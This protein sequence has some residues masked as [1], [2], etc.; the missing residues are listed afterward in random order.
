MKEDNVE[1]I[2]V[3]L[4]G[5]KIKLEIDLSNCVSCLKYR[6]FETTKIHP[7][8]QTLKYGEKVLSNDAEAITF[9]G[10]GKNS[11]LALSFKQF[12]NTLP[13]SYKD[14]FF[15]KDI[16]HIHEQSENSIRHLRANLLAIASNWD[17]NQTYKF[18]SYL[19]NFSH[20]MPLTFAFCLLEKE[21]FL[22]QAHRIA[23][24]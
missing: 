20:N 7:K 3:T 9:Y 10:I 22:S 19:Q 23:L 2:D 24:E 12:S 4:N 8:N 18:I 5:E 14:K 21:G 15:Y 1:P 13:F 17:E 16:Q 6:L 11:I